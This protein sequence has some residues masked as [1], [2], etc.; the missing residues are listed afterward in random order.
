MPILFIQVSTV[1]GVQNMG[2]V[3]GSLSALTLFGIC[4]W[5]FGFYFEVVGD[6]QLK[7][8]LADP[9]NK[10]AL[11]TGGLWHYTRHPN[12]FG[13]VCL[14]WGI[15]VLAASSSFPVML[16]GFAVPSAVLAL[17]GPL[18]ITFLILKVSG[19]PMLE[20]SMQKRPDFAAY[21]ARTNMFVPWFPKKM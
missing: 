9:I 4:V 5:A 1:S 19:V 3:F 10:G 7:A 6:R 13:E 16:L 17:V 14:W 8:F 20:A 11:C 21:A 15:W 2:G 12:Y 18:T